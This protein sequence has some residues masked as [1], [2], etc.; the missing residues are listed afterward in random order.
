MK[1]SVAIK[2]SDTIQKLKHTSSLILL[3]SGLILFMGSCA[4]STAV[5]IAPCDNVIIEKNSYGLSNQEKR[6]KK[7]RKTRKKYF[8]KHVENPKK[9]PV[10]F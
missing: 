4:S 5:P 9:D 1:R 10:G 6:E 8:N 7:Y 3:F 2:K